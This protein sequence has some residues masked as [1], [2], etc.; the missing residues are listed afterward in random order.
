MEAYDFLADNVYICGPVF[1]IEAVVIAAPAHS[2]D[3]VGKRVNPDINDMPGV[4]FHGNAPFEG[5]AGNRKVFQTGLQEV[6]NH[7]ILSGVWLQKFWIFL[8]IFNDAV[9]V[10]GKAEEVTFFFQKLHIAPTVGAFAVYKLVF[11]EEGFTGRAVPAFI[12]AFVNVALVIKHFEN[13]LYAFYMVIV[14]GTNESV[15]GDMEGFPKLLDAHNDFVGIFLGGH[16]L[17]RGN[18]L[19][20]LA[21]FVRAC[22]EHNVITAQTFVA[23]HGVCRNGAVGMADV[24]LIAGVIDRCGDIE[25]FLCQSYLSFIVFYSGMETGRLAEKEKSRPLHH[26]QRTDK[27]PRYHLFLPRPH[28]GGL[29]GYAPEG[30]H[31]L[32]R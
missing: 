2:G 7:F 11:C 20:F 3:I 15:I 8:H 22:Q 32:A 31:I 5:G 4:K 21:V 1:L 19:N 9:A 17:A 6:A 30:R 26:I 27:H 25:F 16:A 24:Q 14:R 13:F 29:F 18:T 23:R 12:G 10:F 28:R